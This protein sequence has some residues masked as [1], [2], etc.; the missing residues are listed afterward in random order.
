MKRYSFD[1]RAVKNLKGEVAWVVEKSY[2]GDVKNNEYP[3]DEPPM[4]WSGV[5]WVD[6]IAYATKLDE[7]TA[8]KEAARLQDAYDGSAWELLPKDGDGA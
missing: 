1:P 6:Y 4:Y 3:V 7:V 2:L 5:G 8:A